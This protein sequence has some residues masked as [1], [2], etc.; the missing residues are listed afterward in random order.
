M[1]ENG[2]MKWLTCKDDANAENAEPLKTEDLSKVQDLNV[3]LIGLK[4][5]RVFIENKLN[6]SKLGSRFIVSRKIIVGL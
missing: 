6:L 2:L 1:V 4:N 3:M 5:R